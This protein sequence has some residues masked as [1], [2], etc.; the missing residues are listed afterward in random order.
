MRRTRIKI[1]GLTRGEDVDA[2]VEC[3]VDA[4]GIVLVRGSP[5]FVDVDQAAALRA[6]V[7]A[8]VQVVALLMDPERTWVEQ[9]LEGVQPDLLQF[10]GRETADF[11]VSWGRGYVKAV[12][13]RGRDGP[14]IQ[15]EIDA[16]AQARGLLLDA[17][18]PGGQGGSGQQFDWSRLPRLERSRLILAGGLRPDNIRDAIGRVR[19][20]AVDLSSG[21]ESA[22]GIKVK[23]KIIDLV[24]Q[25]RQADLECA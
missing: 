13:M 4:I 12:A 21:V 7:P 11:C 20:V 2:C 10:H 23:E 9:V 8:F 24:R 18:A 6:R 3:G 16:H 17:H 19:P 1:C 25:V 22:P 5:R 15:Q 14:A